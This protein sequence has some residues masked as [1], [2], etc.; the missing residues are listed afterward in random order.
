VGTS[1]HEE[2]LAAARHAKEQFPI[3]MS[4]LGVTAAEVRDENDK[5]L[6]RHAM[7]P[8]PDGAEPPKRRRLSL[9]R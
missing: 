3:K 9:R 7:P 4:R 2:F 5:C 1:S 6:L 8:E